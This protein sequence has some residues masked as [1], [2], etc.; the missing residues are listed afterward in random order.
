MK[1]YCDPTLP[2]DYRTPPR[3]IVRNPLDVAW[4]VPE[5]RLQKRLRF[6]HLTGRSPSDVIATAR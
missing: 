3:C 2:H 1:L 6:Q 5:K 4:T